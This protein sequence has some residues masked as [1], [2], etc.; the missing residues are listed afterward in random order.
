MG[1]H[2]IPAVVRQLAVDEGGKS[3]T[4]VLLGRCRTLGT[5]LLA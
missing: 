3:V 5:V 1:Q 4:E 2:S